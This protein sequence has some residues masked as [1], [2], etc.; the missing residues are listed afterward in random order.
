MA[1]QGQLKDGVLT[2]TDGAGKS[3]RLRIV[4]QMQNS[5]FQNGLLMSEANFLK[6]YPRHEGYNF[7]PDRCAALGLADHIRQLLDR[8]LAADGFIAEPT[9]SRSRATGRGNT[10]LSTFQALG[11][12]GLLGAV[13]LAVVLPCVVCGS[14]AANWPSCGRS[15]IAIA[16]SAGLC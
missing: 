7:F 2:V 12:L 10:Y 1:F 13:G 6:L 3:Q 11:G 16:R 4:G 9:I 14:G 5:I 8:S 15:V